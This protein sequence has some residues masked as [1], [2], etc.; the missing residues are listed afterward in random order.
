MSAPRACQGASMG[1]GERVDG[2]DGSCILGDVNFD[3]WPQNVS[4]LLERGDVEG[5][6]RHKARNVELDVH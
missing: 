4:F 6:E 5:D 1:W 3:G 2:G